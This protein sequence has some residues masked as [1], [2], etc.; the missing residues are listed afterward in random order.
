MLRSACVAGQCLYGTDSPDQRSTCHTVLADQIGTRR[1]FHFIK[2][3]KLRILLHQYRAANV[4]LREQ[5]TVCIESADGRNDRYWKV[6]DV[7][8]RQPLQ[9]WKRLPA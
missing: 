4:M 5:G 9:F 3:C 1:G 7:L 6:I 2:E 8:R